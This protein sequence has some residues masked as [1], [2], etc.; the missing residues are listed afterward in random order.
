MWIYPEISCENDLYRVMA[1][2]NDQR[3]IF[4]FSNTAFSVCVRLILD[5]KLRTRLL[6]LHYAT[7]HMYHR[8]RLNANF[9]FSTVIAWKK[10]PLRRLAQY[11]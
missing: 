2:L 1:L 3:W 5:H 11:P 7:M 9:Q 10:I 6:V 4:G 8:D